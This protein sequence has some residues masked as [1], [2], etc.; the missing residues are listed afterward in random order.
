MRSEAEEDA[1]RLMRLVREA[2]PARMAF[3]ILLI[4]D[5]G[6]GVIGSEVMA[7]LPPDAFAP[8]LRRWL[9]RYDAGEIA[10]EEKTGDFDA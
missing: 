8:I 6:N 7:T 5:L 2:L 4:D 9:E 1:V 10:G 3:V